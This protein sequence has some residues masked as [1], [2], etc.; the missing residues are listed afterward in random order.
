MEDGGIFT[1]L[2]KIMN[3]KGGHWMEWASMLFNSKDKAQSQSINITASKMM[4]SD[5]I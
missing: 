1:Q 3:I 2:T 4:V 5:T